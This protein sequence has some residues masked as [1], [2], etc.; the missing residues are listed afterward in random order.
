MISLY[1]SLPPPQIPFYYAISFYRRLFGLKDC[2][3]F[4]SNVIQ[5]PIHLYCPSYFYLFRIFQLFFIKETIFLCVLFFYYDVAKIKKLINF[6]QTKH[7]IQLQGYRKIMVDW[8]VAMNNAWFRQL[9]S[10][11]LW[12]LI[13]LLCSYYDVLG[14]MVNIQKTV[15][16]KID[17]KLPT[18]TFR[19]P[20]RF[21]KTNN[22]DTLI[23]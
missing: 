7:I 4:I 8:L 20:F 11:L 3:F 10:D 19:A 22:P 23:S 2:F 6:F 5:T 15:I 9:L 17:W 14:L 13:V 21:N 12:R 18:S 1:F 16:I